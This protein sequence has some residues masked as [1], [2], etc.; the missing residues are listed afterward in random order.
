VTE[1]LFEARLGS[2]AHS[3]TRTAKGGGVGINNR[4]RR[5]AKQRVRE[6]RQRA[7]EER[8]G[9]SPAAEHPFAAAFRLPRQGPDVAQMVALITHDAVHAID[10][11]DAEALQRHRDALADGPG[12]ANARAVDLALFAVLQRELTEVWGRGWQP[13]DLLRVARRDRGAR[14]CRVIGDIIAGEMRQY[15]TATVDESWEAQLR[16]IGS[17]VWWS[18]DDEFLPGLADREGGTRAEAIGWLLESL[19]VFATCS[20]IQMLTPPPGKGR[21]GSLDTAGAG[22]V[23]E[24]KLDRVRALLA[25]AEATSFAEEA[26]AYSAKA[27][28]LMARHSIDYALLAAGSG[29]RDEPIARRIGIENP[30][31]APKVLLLDAVARAN[32]CRTVWSQSLGFVTALGF[33]ADVAAVE[34]LFTS[35]LVQATTA[36]MRAGKHQDRDGRSSTRSFRQSFLTAYAQRIGERLSATTEQVT[37]ETDRD[38]S[39]RPGSDRL[40]P[41]LA[42]RHKAVDSMTE[43][44]FPAVLSRSVSVTNHS[45]WASGRA[46]A[47][48]ARLTAQSAVEG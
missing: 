32:R 26:E 22:P 13:V 48:R 28:E 1:W 25:K 6:E 36:M 18:G 33:A 34:L 3:T 30:Y 11:K 8:T 14:T 19:H 46:A 4:E 2:V 40:L 16:E 44:L 41:V 12:G 45:G 5:K 38:L 29:T 24:R 15:A 43:D 23:D 10:L 20:S 21:R 47:D 42:A 9:S 17:T 7:R 31:G 35:L 37:A 27:Q 39:A